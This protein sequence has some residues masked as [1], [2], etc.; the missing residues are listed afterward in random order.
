MNIETEHG[1]WTSYGN[2]GRMTTGAAETTHQDPAGTG[3]RARFVNNPHGGDYG[4]GPLA[5]DAATAI[6]LLKAERAEL[7]E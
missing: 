5:D 3:Y 4:W 6:D 1:T 2:D 7:S